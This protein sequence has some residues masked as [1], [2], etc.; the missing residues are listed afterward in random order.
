MARKRTQ[1]STDVALGQIDINE[2]VMSDPVVTAAVY[3]AEQFSRD[4][5]KP[6]YRSVVRRS[7]LATDEFEGMLSHAEV[8]QESL[9]ELGFEKK[10]PKPDRRM[11]QT[12]MMS[13]DVLSPLMKSLSLSAYDRAVLEAIYSQILASPYESNCIFTVRGLFKTMCG[14]VGG[15]TSLSAEQKQMIC[16]TI[17]KLMGT[18][19]TVEATG[20]TKNGVNVSKKT[21]FSLLSAKIEEINVGGNETTS[22]RILNNPEFLALAKLKGGI[23]ATPIDMLNIPKISKTVRNTAIVNYLQHQ[24]SNVTFS[25]R[26][27]TNRQS[28]M[29][30][31]V[32]YLSYVPIYEIAEIKPLMSVEKLSPSKYT[33]TYMSRVRETVHRILDCWVEKG[34][35]KAWADQTGANHHIEGVSVFLH[36]ESLH[37]EL[38]PELAV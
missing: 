16:N 15:D 7:I 38:T 23:T 31:N 19:V 1:K 33:R 2:L 34:Y 28:L 17:M 30:P 27:D 10:N 35:I 29:T 4:S 14:S 8:S 5:S 11:K 9:V 22:V 25:R 24:V 13:E 12:V 20:I 36:E 32:L 3:A 6:L 37:P 26:A 21:T 18:V